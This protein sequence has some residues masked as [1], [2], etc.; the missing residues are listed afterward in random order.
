MS[1]KLGEPPP[2]QPTNGKR[3][4]LRI[5]SSAANTQIFRRVL[6]K[7]SGETVIGPGDAEPEPGAAAGEPRSRNGEPEPEFSAVADKPRSEARNMSPASAEE[8]EP[9]PDP[10]SALRQLAIAAEP[11]LVAAAIPEPVALPKRKAKPKESESRPA[12]T[13]RAAASWPPKLPSKDPDWDDS[14]EANE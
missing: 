9:S 5:G 14:L 13:K 7:M 1:A 6:E 2:I 8:L 10:V 4:L 3:G 12:P 11:D